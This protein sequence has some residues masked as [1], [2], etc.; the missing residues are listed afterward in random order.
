MIIVSSENNHYYYYNQ[1]SLSHICVCCYYT[2]DHYHAYHTDY[3]RCQNDAQVDGYIFNEEEKYYK[4]IIWE[5]AN[6]EYLEVKKIL[7]YI[8]CF[9]S[10][11]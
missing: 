7:F 4:K 5:S 3:S 8:C 10:A 2:I 6:R 1:L 9:N 11:G